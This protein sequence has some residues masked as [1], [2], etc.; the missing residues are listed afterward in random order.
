MN[1]RVDKT[2]QGC[3]IVGM[4][5]TNTPFRVVFVCTGN[6]CRSPMARAVF[7]RLIDEAGLAGRVASSSA[8][9]G[10]WHVGERA[11]NRTLEILQQR[12]YDGSVHRARQ[13]ATGDFTAN[14]LIVAM[15]RSHERILQHWAPN[16]DSRDRIALL[17]GLVGRSDG[18]LDIPDPY[19]GEIEDFELVMDIVEDAIRNLVEQLVPA[20]RSMPQPGVLRSSADAH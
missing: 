10:D 17:L 5:A 16:D 3:R 6:T 4:P 18:V 1:L 19:H 9:T 13:F 7:D 12:G 20:L 8:G 2:G 15:D 14:D 11:D